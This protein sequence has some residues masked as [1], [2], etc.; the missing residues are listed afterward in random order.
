MKIENIQLS[1]INNNELIE[2][3]KILSEYLEYLELE[4]KNIEEKEE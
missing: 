2:I 1:K 3:E 4:L